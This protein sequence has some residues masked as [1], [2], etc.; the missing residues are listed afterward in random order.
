M[1]IYQTIEIETDGIVC[2]VWLNRPDVHNAMNDIMISELTSVFRDFFEEENLRLIILRGRGKSFCAGADLHYMK[3]I[4]AYGAEENLKDSI[5]LAQLFSIIY[6]CHVP[7]I[8]LV[9]GAC[10]GGGNGLLSACDIALAGINTTF[11]FSEAK[12]GIAPSTIAPFVIRR[13][14]EYGAKE[15][16][17]TAKHFKGEEAARWNLINHAYPE[18]ELENALS[19]FK[20]QILDCGPHAVRATKELIGQVVH[21][22]HDM[23]EILDYTTKLITELRASEEGQEG[24]SAFLQ[25]RK[26]NWIL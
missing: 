26:P 8:S 15:L 23:V 13:I 24:M 16:M 17:M 3:D 10:F 14:G 21:E 18:S 11:A 22:H 1:K 5:K 19:K 4:A 6:E 12:I 20:Q 7:T 2:T 9:H 25:K